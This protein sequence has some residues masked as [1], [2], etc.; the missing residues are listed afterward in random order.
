[1]TLSHRRRRGIAGIAG[2]AAMSLFGV[3]AIPAAAPAAP[4]AI[5]P[6]TVPAVPDL[7]PAAVPGPAPGAVPAFPAARPDTVRRDQWQLAELKAD[8]AWRY[9]TGAGVVVGV[10][11][12][13]VDAKHPDLAGQVLPGLD[14]VTPAQDGRTDPVGHGTTVA[15]LI[16]GSARDDRGAVGLAPNAKILPIRVLNAD[17]RYEDALV[18]AQ[19]VRWAVDHGARV[20]NLSL[21]G[22]GTS[23]ALAEALDY[24]FAKDVVVIACT[25]NVTP[26]APTDVWYPAREPG[27]IA[28]SGLDRAHGTL[29][30]SSI[31]GPATVI[32]AP[33]TSL[34]GARPGGH[35]RVQG[36]SF[37]APLVSATA[38]LIR[39]RWPTMSAANV[40]NRLI[41]TARDVGPTGRD[42][43][44][45]FG[46]LDPV[47]ALTR[48]LP[49]VE[50]NP[51]DTLPPP[52]LAGFGPAPGLDEKAQT[53]T[54]G[55]RASGGDTGPHRAAGGWAEPLPGEAP[56]GE[57]SRGGLL[58]GVAALAALVT[59]GVLVVRRRLRRG[60]W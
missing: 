53:P 46:A 21:G 16:A 33:A 51:L 56:Q 60:S 24:A 47:A 36:T 15:G 13:G 40:V 59:G 50:T 44:Y 42:E 49:T 39:S 20:L 6:A 58:G 28:V 31:T 32:S 30:A 11:D 23:A 2:A 38:A 17:N 54:R 29:W 4:P 1:V 10:L 34:V 3:G 55:V 18:V 45:G 8:T 48:D 22:I 5:T 27:V 57:Q 26:T 19:G 12:S 9:S 43:S 7:A 52:G 41:S 35:W 14:L 37:A 25:G